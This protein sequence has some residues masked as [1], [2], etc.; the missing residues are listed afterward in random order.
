MTLYYYYLSGSCYTFGLCLKSDSS[1]WTL[2]GPPS[3]IG[4]W[5]NLVEHTSLNHWYASIAVS[6]PTLGSF[7]ASVT[8]YSHTHQYSNPSRCWRLNLLFLKRLPA[9]NDLVVLQEP[10]RKMQPSDM[11][12]FCLS[13]IAVPQLLHTMLDA[14]KCFCCR[15]SI[16]SSLFPN[17]TGPTS[18]IEI[19]P[20]IVRAYLFPPIYRSFFVPFSYCT[21]TSLN[22]KPSSGR[23][24]V[25]RWSIRHT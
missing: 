1:I 25:H 6:L 19:F 2:P 13:P 24:L 11:S 4:V 10:Q 21:C 3:W 9:L 16:S 5:T 12:D 7:A 20:T 18:M 17:I 23:G 14:S 22:N 8:G 15:K